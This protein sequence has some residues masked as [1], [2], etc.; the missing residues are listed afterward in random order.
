MKLLT[1]LLISL[2]TACATPNAGP[3]ADAGSTLVALNMIEGAKEANPLLAAAGPVGG[4]LLSIGL[5]TAVNHS[6]RGD[7]EC[8]SVAG[9][10]DAVGYGALCNNAAAMLGAS[11]LA[12]GALMVF[13]SIRAKKARADKID[14][15]C[16]EHTLTDSPCTMDSLP[17]G[18]TRARCIDGRLAWR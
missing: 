15:W 4:P 13:C 3:A 8:A 1:A 7:P 10:T 11:P 5:R 9:W 16:S 6:V 14:A 17:D 18:F 12:G 2:L